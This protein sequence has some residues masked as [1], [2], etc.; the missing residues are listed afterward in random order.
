M[1]GKKCSSCKA[2]LPL[3][4]PNNHYSHCVILDKIAEAKF[5]QR[6]RMKRAAYGSANILE[7]L[8]CEK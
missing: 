8:K 2:D 6:L 7:D 3:N 4:H 1:Q 5:S